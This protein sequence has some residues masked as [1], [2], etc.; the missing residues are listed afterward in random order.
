MRQLINRLR[1]GMASR[2]MLAFAALI[3]P[4]ALF[5]AWSYQRSL[6]DRRKTSVDDA[7]SLG[8]T[9]AAI[10][11]GVLRDLDST[12]LAMSQA[13]G[14]QQIP[15][16]QPIVGPYLEAVGQKSPLLRT[17][18]LMDPNG[19]IIA[20]PSGQNLGVDLSNRPYTKALMSGQDFVLSE[21]IQGSE[22]GEPTITMARA[23]R[24]PDGTL[25]GYLAAAFYPARLA[26]VFPGSLPQ[27][28][29]LNVFDRSGTLIY[30][31]YFQ[32]LSTEQLSSAR[33]PRVQGAVEG[34]VVR[35]PRTTETLDGQE[36]LAVAV[37]VSEYGW[38][39]SI[40][41]RLDAL[42]A[43]LAESFRRQVAVLALVTLVA[44]A[45]AMILSEA[46][47]RPL[48]RLAAHARAFGHGEATVPAPASGP[49]EVQALADALN[50][51][52]LQVQERFA[53]REAALEE[54][55]AALAVRDQFLSVAA[56]ELR[57]P[58]TAMKGQV[59]LA[60]RLLVRGAAPAE[61]I[62]LVER[63]DAQADRL[64]GLITDLLDVSRISA[65]RFTI[66]PEP[67]ALAA[68]VERTVE[69]ER[70]AMPPRDIR[71]EM[72][73]PGLVV[74]ADPARLEQVLINLLENARK[75]SP[76]DRPIHV[77]VTS[78]DQTVQIAVRDEGIGIPPQ[79]LDQIF[80]RF[81]RA[82][83][84]DDSV[85]G[86]GLGLYITHEIVR[87][88][89]GELQVESQPGEGSTFTVV[90]PC[91]GQPP[92]SEPTPEKGEPADPPATPAATR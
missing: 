17:F 64:T 70:G 24:A 92:G 2:L 21:V 44:L 32:S 1:G 86:L 29:I 62:L 15:L 90:L 74:E 76:E 72:P 55:R 53:E 30:S 83:N 82:G 37:P 12:T 59:Q 66:A 46:L 77:R 84:V 69:M 33:V 81:H 6:E 68:L 18:F 5:S 34:T 35:I 10:V 22:T 13:L 25:R 20:T 80:E 45:L 48:A 47:S 11:H 91:V 73:D 8:Q 79:D 57:T 50:T 61:V 78:A 67:V 87:A 49:N 58:L 19:I 40:S 26:T 60:R 88:H 28:A 65:G 71:V 27:D 16:A 75:Y 51:M 31:S 3:L 4:L 38:A 9:A 54:A 89:G 42:D 56:H 63:A 52:A 39:V 41:R 14:V 43:P 36:R 7:V 23:V 85:S